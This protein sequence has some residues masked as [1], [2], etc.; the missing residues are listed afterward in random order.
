MSK[1]KRNKFWQ[2]LPVECSLCPINKYCTEHQ[3]LD[4]HEVLY[5]FY[6]EETEE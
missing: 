3:R 1:M 2:L 5:K 6:Q 4:C